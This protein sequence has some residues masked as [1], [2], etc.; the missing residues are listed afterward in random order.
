[1][2]I[3]SHNLHEEQ[4]EETLFDLSKTTFQALNDGCKHLPILPIQFLYKFCDVAGHGIQITEETKRIGFDILSGMPANSKS[5]PSNTI[6]GDLCSALQEIVNDNNFTLPSKQRRSL[7]N[8]LVQ[9]L[10]IH[11][12]PGKTL[13][14]LEILQMIMQE[15]PS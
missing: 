11:A 12:I 15:S 6:D 7:V 5:I 9:Y 8:K 14:S 3:L 10:E 13:Q 2:E 4:P 1:L